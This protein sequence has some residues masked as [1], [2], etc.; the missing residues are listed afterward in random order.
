MCFLCDIDL[1]VGADTYMLMFHSLR[2]EKVKDASD[3]DGEDHEAEPDDNALFGD[4]PVLA[5]GEELANRAEDF[6][7]LTLISNFNFR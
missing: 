6:K 7:E 1:G 2:H 4:R 5:V 3:D